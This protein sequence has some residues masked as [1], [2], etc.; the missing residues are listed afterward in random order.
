MLAH[1]LKSIDISVLSFLTKHQKS[2]FTRLDCNSAWDILSY[3]PKRYE[4][5]TKLGTIQL[6]C[7]EKASSRVIVQKHAYIPFRNTRVLQITVSDATMQAYL[8]CYGRNFI[9]KQLPVGQTVLLYTQFSK[10]YGKWTSSQFEYALEKNAD[11]FLT[12]QPIYH[13]KKGIRQVS[14]QNLLKKSVLCITDQ[15]E[16]DIDSHDLITSGIEGANQFTYSPSYLAALYRAIHIPPN[17]PST[18]VA[19]MLIAFR[20]LIHIQVRFS[21]GSI[22]QS[23][24][25]E[26]TLHLDPAL[27]EN[28]PF[29]LTEGQLTAVSD[30]LSHMQ[31]MRTGRRIIQGDVGCGKT[32]VALL[33]AIVLAQQGYQTIFL[34]PT[35]LLALQHFENNQALLQKYSIRSAFLHRNLAADAVHA[36]QEDFLQGSIDILFGTH[37]LLHETIEGKNLALLIID[38]QQRFGVAQRQ[39]LTKSQ[40]P[41]PYVLMLSAT[42]IPRSV[43]QIIS[44]YI[45]VSTITEKPLD[46]KPIRT[47]LS[48]QKNIEQAYRL[49]E[50][51]LDK[52]H[53]AYI[54]YPRI[55]ESNHIRSIESMLQSVQSRFAAYNCGV[56]H[57]QLDAKMISTTMR[58]FKERSIHVLLASSIIEVGID[59]KNASILL[60]EHAE[61]FGLSTLHQLRG[62]IGRSDLQSYCCLAYAEDLTDIAKE[63]LKI[64]YETS[65]GFLIAEKDLLLR[66]PGDLAGTH[67]SGF[68]AQEFM[69][70]LRRKDLLESSQ[71]IASKI[72]TSATERDRMGIDHIDSME[73]P[74]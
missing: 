42:P 17:M 51:E 37:K 67:Q 12:I 27:F 53:Q 46:R 30:I 63:R 49:I 58:K 3:F 2:I 43:A 61:L 71:K 9:A 19:H 73:S 65:D 69:L 14:L 35:Y 44:G 36:L 50:S 21:I 68:N 32:I 33:V 18:K 26:K 60:I 6:Q 47:H 57:S 38:E 31:K 40:F 66:G 10:S 29:Q 56:V 7:T 8:M 39:A 54:V 16:D 13:L 15:L 52:G 72:L 45:T 59:V 74:L 20:N 55:A 1:E 22:A 5:R 23:Y 28:L 48:T 64:M 70:V 62:R 24:P 11:A 4:D 41:P 34:A 25:L